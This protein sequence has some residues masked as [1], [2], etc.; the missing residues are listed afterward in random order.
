[1]HL[2]TTAAQ[3]GWAQLA[4]GALIQIA[5]CA[6]LMFFVTGDQGIVY[7]RNHTNRRIPIVM[8]SSSYWP[9]VDRP[10]IGRRQSHL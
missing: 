10:A 7:Q 5:D 4:N 2:V 1:M 8:I 6:G 3:M 9:A